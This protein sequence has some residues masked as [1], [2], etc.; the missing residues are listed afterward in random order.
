MIISSV[1]CE[2]FT[3]MALADSDSRSLIIGSTLKLLDVVDPTPLDAPKVVPPDENF[4]TTFEDP[5]LA[6]AAAA[7]R[8]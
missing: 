4:E 1:N 7:V 2:L 5:V 8:P 6:P 3:P